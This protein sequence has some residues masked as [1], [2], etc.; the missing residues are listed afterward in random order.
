VEMIADEMILIGRGKIVAQG[1]KK[2]LLASSTVSTL[3]TSLD[4]HQL[5]SALEQAGI[6]HATAGEGFMVE[7]APADV[8]RVAVEHRIVLTD[9]RAGG[10]G[11]EDLFLELTA[12]TQREGHI[13]GASS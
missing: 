10:A 11:L 6:K 7:A 9:L 4:N 5:G 3:V 12:D 1:D 8:G 2:S 13:E